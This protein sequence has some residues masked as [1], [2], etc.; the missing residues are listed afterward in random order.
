MPPSTTLGVRRSDISRAYLPPAPPPPL[1]CHR[2]FGQIASPPS[3]PV[4][5]NYQNKINIILSHDFPVRLFR[6]GASPPLIP[7]INIYVYKHNAHQ[8]HPIRPPMSLFGRR[9]SPPCHPNPRPTPRLLGIRLTALLLPHIS[10]PCHP[11]SSSSS[12]SLTPRLLNHAHH[13]QRLILLIPRCSPTVSSLTSL[14]ISKSLIG[15]AAINLLH[16][17]LRW[18]NQF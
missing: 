18:D 4:P 16:W 7:D 14:T 1:P 11:H 2:V 12:S 15:E 10:P 17:I 8:H 9:A 6:Q 3:C 13:H 5:Q